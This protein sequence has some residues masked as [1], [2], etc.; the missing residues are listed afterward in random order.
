[1]DEATRKAALAKL[2]AFEPRIGHPVK[3]IDYSS[4]KVERGDLLG[5]AMRV[6]EFEHGTPALAPSASRS[7]GRCGG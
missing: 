7:T 4:L 6:A 5:N 2:A 1:M 3:Y